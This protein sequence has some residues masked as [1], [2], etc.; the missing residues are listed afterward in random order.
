MGQNIVNGKL[1]DHTTI[2]HGVRQGGDTGLRTKA[3]IERVELML[4]RR[5]QRHGLVTLPGIWNLKVI[6]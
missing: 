6:L 1:S 5:K 2:L 4:R 3:G